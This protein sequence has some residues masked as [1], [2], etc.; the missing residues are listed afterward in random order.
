MAGA[1]VRSAALPPRCAASPLHALVL[2]CAL[3]RARA[4]PELA[5]SDYLP[6]G[7]RCDSRAA[8]R[9]TA[10]SARFHARPHRHFFFRALLFF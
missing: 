3:A 7:A 6:P 9:R 10:Q 4:Q 1:S 5:G 8:H 2:V